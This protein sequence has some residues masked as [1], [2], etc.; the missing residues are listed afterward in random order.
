MAGDSPPQGVEAASKLV[1]IA[2]MVPS[3]DAA[4]EVAKMITEKEWG[5]SFKFAEKGPCG[6]CVPVFGGLKLGTISYFDP[7]KLTKEDWKE[8]MEDDDDEGDD[9]FDTSWDEGDDSALF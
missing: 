4:K 7:A 6:I 1:G 2:M 3:I 5:F 9:L 8:I